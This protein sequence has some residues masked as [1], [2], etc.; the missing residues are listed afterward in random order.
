MEKFGIDLYI[1]ALLSTKPLPEALNKIVNAYGRSS[2]YLD[3]APSHYP[4]ITVA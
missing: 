2:G 1:T 4:K 3:C